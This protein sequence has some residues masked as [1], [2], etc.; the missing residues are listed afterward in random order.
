MATVDTKTLSMDFSNLFPE[1][2]AKIHSLKN[3]LCRDSE[4]LCWAY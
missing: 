3:P 1:D 4:S 2:M